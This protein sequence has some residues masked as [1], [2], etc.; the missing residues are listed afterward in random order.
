MTIPAN[1]KDC[2]KGGPRSLVSRLP[3]TTRFRIFLELKDGAYLEETARKYGLNSNNLSRFMYSREF[4][5]FEAESIRMMFHA[6]ALSP[7][8]LEYVV[9]AETAAREKAKGRLIA[10]GRKSGKITDE[11][12]PWAAGL[13]NKA[14]RVW[15]RYAPKIAPSG[16]DMKTNS[17]IHKE[18]IHK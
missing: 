7:A 14:L 2:N 12:L 13:D 17:K 5:Q 6:V 18:R 3:Y 1:L 15:L 16:K 10:E 11:I 4:K 8:G 9:E